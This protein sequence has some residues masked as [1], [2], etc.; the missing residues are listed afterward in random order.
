MINTAL[1]EDMLAYIQRLNTEL[2][3]RCK[4]EHNLLGVIND[5]GTKLSETEDK[6]SKAEDKLVVA[7]ERAENYHQ[8]WCDGQTNLDKFIEFVRNTFLKEGQQI[9]FN[10]TTQEYEIVENP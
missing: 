7:N 4:F 2:E 3:S 6:L 10:T 8:S 5:L 9:V 1:M